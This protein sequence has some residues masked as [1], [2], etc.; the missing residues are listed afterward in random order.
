MNTPPTG[1]MRK[2]DPYIANDSV[3]ADAEPFGKKFSLLV[4]DDDDGGDDADGGDDDEIPYYINK[5]AKDS[6]IIIL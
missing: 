4:V 6:K 5:T 1:R 3:N 2:A